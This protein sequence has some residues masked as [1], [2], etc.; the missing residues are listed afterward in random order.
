MRVPVARR[1]LKLVP[2]ALCAGGIALLGQPCDV[3]G[4]RLDRVVLAQRGLE[5]LARF[6]RAAV[7]GER[8][9]GQHGDLVL[10]VVVA[11]GAQ[12]LERLQRFAP[13][14]GPPAASSALARPNCSSGSEARRAFQRIAVVP[15]G[16]GGLARSSAAL[17]RRSLFCAVGARS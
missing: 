8:S 16:I 17:A 4:A 15:D 3:A 12:G 1:L 2:L 10:A 7:G 9:G 11:R 13:E 5:G 6:L 14:A